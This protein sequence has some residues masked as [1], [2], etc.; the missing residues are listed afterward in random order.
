MR[1][2]AIM[3]KEI[4]S[5]TALSKEIVDM[6]SLLNTL[7]ILNKVAENIQKQMSGLY[8]DVR[9]TYKPDLKGFQ[10]FISTKSLNREIVTTLKEKILTIPLAE[11]KE[12]VTLKQK[13]K[14]KKKSTEF[15][16][17]RRY[18]FVQN[19]KGLCIYLV[20][21]GYLKKNNDQTVTIPT[22][23]LKVFWNTS[24]ATAVRYL[25][26]LLQEDSVELIKNGGAK[27]AFQKSFFKIKDL[28]VTY[29]RSDTSC[30]EPLK[31][32]LDDLLASH[33]EGN[34]VTNTRGHVVDPLYEYI[35][36]K[37]NSVQLTEMGKFA[38]QETPN[39]YK[40]CLVCEY[41]DNTASSKRSSVCCKK[42]MTNKHWSDYCDSFTLKKM[43]QK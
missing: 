43:F 42:G 18:L 26:Y 36:K 5:C 2:E 39:V 23:W 37:T 27:H 25:K 11:Q 1:L 28:P 35:D 30:Y 33:K 21:N 7:D 10:F 6:Q 38:S 24:R 41:N 3:K 40:R 34:K 17:D 22:K 12:E 14:R 8:V 20:Q 9:C 15:V 32:Y 4:E 19:V 13:K 29:L 16:K 31:K